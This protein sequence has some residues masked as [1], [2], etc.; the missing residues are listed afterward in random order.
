[1]RDEK[2]WLTVVGVMAAAAAVAVICMLLATGCQWAEVRE[3]Y[4]Q[5]PAAATS[6]G[7]GSTDRWEWRRG[8]W[9]RLDPPMQL[10]RWQGD[11]WVMV[12]RATMKPVPKI[13]RS[14]TEQY[15]GGYERYEKTEKHTR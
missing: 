9:V 2:P 1:M 11:K 8:Q 4:S 13:E 10:W 12:D 15:D 7:E 14:V 3:S 5:T 6:V